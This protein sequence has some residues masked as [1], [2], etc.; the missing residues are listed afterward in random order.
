MIRNRVAVTVVVCAVVCAGCGMSRDEAAPLVEEAV[1][2]MTEDLFPDQDYEFETGQV[3]GDLGVDCYYFSVDTNVAPVR[4]EE[5]G[6]EVL[7]RMIEYADRVFGEHGE[8]HEIG[9]SAYFDFPM[10]GG[11]G[12]ASVWWDTQSAPEAKDV[13]IQATTSDCSREGIASVDE[14]R[15]SPAG[16]G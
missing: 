8:V 16:G 6:R 10:E 2:T 13:I 1:V 5:E 14:E 11:S 15:R 9:A 7:G 4:S 3:G 12:K